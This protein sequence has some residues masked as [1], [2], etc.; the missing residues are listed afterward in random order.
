VQELRFA[1][2]N[3]QIRMAN[4]AKSAAVRVPP[5]DPPTDIPVLEGWKAHKRPPFQGILYLILQFFR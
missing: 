1:R 4:R 3:A 2:A 5:A